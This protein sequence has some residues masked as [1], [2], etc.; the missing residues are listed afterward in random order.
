M[1]TDLEPPA[2][3]DLPPARAAQLRASLLRR[4]QTRTP[5]RHRRGL[6]LAVAATLTVAA[7]FGVLWVRPQPLPT[8]LAMGPGELSGSLR[9]VVDGCLASR[10]TFGRTAD[11]YRASAG[12]PP[13]PDFPVAA[14]DVA[15]AAEADGRALALFLTG[16]G[17]LACGSE[18]HRNPIT[19][20]RSEPS[21]GLAGDE[22]GASRDWLPGPVQVLFLSSSDEEAGQV[23][24]AGRVSP[25][26]A[27]LIVDD[28][29][30]RTFRARLADGAFGLLITEPLDP[31][32]RLIGYDAAGEVVFEGPLFEGAFARVKTCYTDDTGRIVYRP[33]DP[34]EPTGKCLPAE[35]WRH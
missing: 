33:D 21:G 10:A 26:V 17:Y 23:T 13:E 24:A 27:R 19:G 30:G 20:L 16:R 31:G 8:T 34:G 1:I 28:G 7:A 6:R 35:P 12:L 3:R 11:E 9:T 5:I 32:A 25:R 29:S 15:V 22:W 4:T 2:E 18:Q 14:R